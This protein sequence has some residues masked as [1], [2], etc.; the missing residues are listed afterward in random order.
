[1]GGPAQR[2]DPIGPTCASGVSTA[3]SPERFH[4]QE[5]AT[6]VYAKTGNAIVVGEQG[7]AGNL[8]DFAG[9]LVQAEYT[10]AVITHK[11]EFAGGINDRAAT[12]NLVA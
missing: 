4:N 9:S 8:S 2:F 1:M 3:A 11:E 10:K 12:G 7:R 5:V 6:G